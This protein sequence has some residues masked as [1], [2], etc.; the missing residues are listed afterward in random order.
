VLELVR[1]QDAGEPPWTVLT[2]A[3]EA[4]TTELH[5]E[6][7]MHWLV[8]RR[9]LRGHPG[10]MAHRIAAWEAV[11]REL[12]VAVKPRLT[13]AHTEL[14]ARLLA[15]TFLTT[16]RVAIQHWNDHQDGPMVDAVLMALGEVAPASEL[17]T[18]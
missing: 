8:Q 17:A 13:G 9:K 11:E 10:L 15:S 12:A 3:A 7:N 5:A 2:R 1:E 18:A 14:R 16:I 6:L 4:F